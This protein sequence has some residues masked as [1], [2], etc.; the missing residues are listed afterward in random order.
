VGHRWVHGGWIAG[1]EAFPEG[2]QQGLTKGIQQSF[3]PLRVGTCAKQ[4]EFIDHPAT[5]WKGFSKVCKAAA[6]GFPGEV[7]RD[8]SCLSAG[9]QGAG[10]SR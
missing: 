6:K 7:G 2:F 10:G 3:P 8:I 9:P 5:L 4:Q 1:E